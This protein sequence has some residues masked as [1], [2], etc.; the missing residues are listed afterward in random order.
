M[1]LSDT[2]YKITSFFEGAA[3]A[4]VP[5]GANVIL[6]SIL[7]KQ[8]SDNYHYINQGFSLG[9]IGLL[10]STHYLTQYRII[11]L[12]MSFFNF[13][14]VS[15]YIATCFNGD[16]KV[17]GQ[18]N[19]VD[20]NLYNILGV[21]SGFVPFL[22]S[23]SLLASKL[24]FDDKEYQDVRGGFIF[25]GIVFNFFALTFDDEIVIPNAI[26]QFLTGVFGDVYISDSP[27]DVVSMHGENS[28]EHAVI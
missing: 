10:A 8:T 1:F 27:Q 4:F 18:D 12:V 15:S 16:Y 14:T 25:G 2:S 24:L 5:S 7:E 6:P 26:I 17:I 11:P 23:A 9:S 21:I 22:G 13:V 20:I 28:L 3:L 19:N